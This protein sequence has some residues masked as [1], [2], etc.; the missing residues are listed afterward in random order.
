VVKLEPE[1]DV[2]VAVAPAQLL[3]VHALL[4]DS[5][6]LSVQQRPVR[7]KSTHNES[8]LKR[9]ENERTR[10]S[11]T[12]RRQGK[13]S[14]CQQ[15]RFHHWENA[16]QSFDDAQQDAGSKAGHCSEWSETRHTAL[17]S[18]QIHAELARNPF[19]RLPVVPWSC[20]STR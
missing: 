6:S 7:Q 15:A 4:L 20:F 5:G 12:R 9:L 19:Q 10:T 14:D 17:F 11:V 2:A 13:N 1:P 18:A 8:K 3:D 16:A